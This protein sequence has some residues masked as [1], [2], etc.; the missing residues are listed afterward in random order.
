MGLRPIQGDEK[1]PRSSNHALWNRC[2]FLCH[3]ER[4]RGI[5]GSADHYWKRGIRR[6]NRIVIS[7]GAKRSGEIC[8]FP[9][10]S[11]GRRKTLNEGHGFSRAASPD[12]DEGFSP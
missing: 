6:S 2:P 4:S 12:A 11:S 5:C 8:G 10:R 7:T 9:F 1:T 3:P